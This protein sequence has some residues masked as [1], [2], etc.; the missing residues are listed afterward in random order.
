M[1]PRKVR[2]AARATRRA[3]TTTE[4]VPLP[5]CDD[6]LSRGSLRAFVGWANKVFDLRRLL[7]GFR[8]GRKDPSVASEAIAASTFFC[9]LLR[10][11][12]FNAL[13]PKLAETPFLRLIGSLPASAP[14]PSKLCCVD[15]VGRALRVADLESARNVVW[16]SLAK[17]E[18]N[19]VFRE[20]WHGTLRYVA[21]DG[22]ESFSSYERCCDQCLVRRVKVERDGVVGEIEQYY[23]RYVVAMLIDERLDLMLDFEPL[24]PGDLRPDASRR[25]SHEGEQTA[26]MRL[27]PRLK[28]RFP[29]VDAVVADSLFPNGPFLTLVKELRMS[30]VIVAKKD[31]DEPLKEALSL[32]EGQPPCE[33]IE[34]RDKQERIE[35]WDCPGLETLSTYKGPIRVVRARIHDLRDP[36]ARPKTWCIVVT[37][38]AATRLG[39]RLVLAVARGRWHL[40]NTGF[41]QWTSRWRFGHVFTHDGTA[42]QALFWLFFAAYNLL[43][44]FLYRQVKSYGRDKGKDQTRTI[45]RF[46][47]ELCDGLAQLSCSPWLDTA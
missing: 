7:G 15:T 22:W 17:A 45:S 27:L 30:A 11:R 28:K 44:L 38:K 42:I 26:A 24:L 46:V 23:H 14:A 18:R 19:K 43:T 31:G 13:E 33:V 20:G 21:I 34:N 6:V 12:S 5:S 36:V 2:R 9:G 40:E 8:D 35:L 37:G 39:R 29:W 32:W 47:D 4:E 10:V 3:A 1:K 16:E 41:H 25:D